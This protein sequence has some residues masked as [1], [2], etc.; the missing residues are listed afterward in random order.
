[1]CIRDR[2]QASYAQQGAPVGVAMQSPQVQASQATPAFGA[3]FDPMT[4]QP[5]PKFDPMTGRQNW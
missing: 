1:M 5:I 2:V 4:G 3:K